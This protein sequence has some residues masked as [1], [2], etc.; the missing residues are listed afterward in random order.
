MAIDQK[1][2]SGLESDAMGSPQQCG[3]IHISSDKIHDV[4]AVEIDKGIKSQLLKEI[5]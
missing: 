3:Q 4:A 5:G 1:D 2:D